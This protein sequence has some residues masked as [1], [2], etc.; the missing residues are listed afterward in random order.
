MYPEP[1]F[2]QKKNY[3]QIEKE[4]LAINYAIKKFHRFIHA[5]KFTLQTDHRPLLT[6][7]VSKKGISMH[8]A[9]RLQCWGIILLNYNF[10]VEFLLSKKNWDTAT[11]RY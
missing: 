7:F 10:K 6:I 8:T 11:C 1:Y 2:L 3:S 9:N 4:S 5:R